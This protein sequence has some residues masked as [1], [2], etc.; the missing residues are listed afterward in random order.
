MSSPREPD[1]A[2]AGQGLQQ[3]LDTVFTSEWLEGLFSRIR[4]SMDA[5][6][7]EKWRS[8]IETNAQLQ[9]ELRHLSTELADTRDELHKS[10]LRVIELEKKKSSR[11]RF[12]D[13]LFAS[14]S[15]REEVPLRF[16]LPLLPT[17]AFTDSPV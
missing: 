1:G 4:E 6:Y 7:F 15:P 16:V 2:R 13:E 12:E 10:R 14:S 9:A 17:G 3:K 8:A 5:S 11:V